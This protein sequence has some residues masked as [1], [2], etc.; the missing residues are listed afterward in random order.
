MLVWTTVGLNPCRK[1]SYIYKYGD[2]DYTW[3]YNEHCVVLTGYDLNDNTVTVYDSIDGI[4]TY[5]TADF[6]AVYD[7]MW[8]MSVV[9]EPR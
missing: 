3:V 5:N 4:M 7:D 2:T 9:L 6:Q 8:K 1:A